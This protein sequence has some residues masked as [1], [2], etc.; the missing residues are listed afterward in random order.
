MGG[1][2]KLYL[3]WHRLSSPPN[4]ASS[5]ALLIWLFQGALVTSAETVKVNNDQ[6][7]QLPAPQMTSLHNHLLHLTLNSL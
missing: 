1:S 7:L 3:Y 2:K 5:T 6:P 4:N